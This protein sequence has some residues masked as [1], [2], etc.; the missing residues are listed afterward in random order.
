[1]EPAILGLISFMLTVT[2][3][4]DRSRRNE[5]RDLRRDMNDGFARTD[6]RTDAFR[7][8]MSAG[9]DTLRQEM[10]DGFARSDA[11][12]DTLRQE[13]NEGFARTDARIDTLRQETNA[14]FD[15]LRQE[16]NEGFARTDARIDLQTTTIINLAEGLGEVKGRTEALAATE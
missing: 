1:M 3:Y 13:T 2:L 9:F 7:Q 14:G 10:K 12:F 8:E 11:R 16:T 15:K 5:T 6:A 4:L